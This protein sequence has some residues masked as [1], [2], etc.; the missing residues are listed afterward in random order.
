MLVLKLVMMMLIAETHF[1]VH[2]GLIE[3]DLVASVGDLLRLGFATVA[4]IS[5]A[6][7][8]VAT[9]ID[10][11]AF[12]VLKHLLSP[13]FEKVVG[14]RVELEPILPIVPVNIKLVQRRG[15]VTLKVRVSHR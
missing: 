14:I 11:H 6:M 10:D 13:Q 15:F 1:A 8:L 4:A 12:R 5:A 3:E 7:R 9:L 2:D